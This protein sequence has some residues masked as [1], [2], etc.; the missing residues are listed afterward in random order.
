MFDDAI[1]KLRDLQ[2]RAE[3]LDGEHS[4]SLNDLFHDEFILRNTDFDS[5][6]AM[7]QA[8][9]FKV[10]TSEDFEAIPDEQWD[11]FV[12]ERTRFTSWEEMK[13]AAVQEWAARQ[14]GFD[15]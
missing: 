15:E 4:V 3:R 6:E 9:G 8:S 2:R 5:I 7:V 1:R 12:R 10:E 11:I 13:G 14:L